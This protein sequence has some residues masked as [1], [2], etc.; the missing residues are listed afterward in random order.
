MSGINRYRRGRVTG[1]AAVLLIVAAL[2]AV[3][4]GCGG[5]GSAS[6][7]AHPTL[8]G[9]PTF[10]PTPTVTPQVVP[11]VSAQT[12]VD[13]AK[14][15]D[16]KGFVAAAAAAG[17]DA[18]LKQNIPYTILAPND[19]AFADLGL[20]QLIKNVPK[21]EAVMGYHVI[22]AE[23]LKIA[24]IKNGQEASTYLGYPVRFTVKDG[25]VMVNDANV[26]KVI[27]GPTWSIFVIDKVLQPPLS[28]TLP[29]VASPSP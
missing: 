27:E 5:S 4:A 11:S 3:A 7:S 23:D 14:A 20:A 17:L 15:G 13:A 28:A 19:Q 18:A 29:P 1:A 6:P 2:A 16:L 26:V 25:A 12:I 8:G 21:A 10:T 9:I 24:R 22:P